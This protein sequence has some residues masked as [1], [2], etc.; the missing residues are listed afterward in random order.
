ML[1]VLLSIIEAIDAIVNISSSFSI[2][3]RAI[4][5]LHG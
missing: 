4:Q 3:E 1:Y 5:C 2:I